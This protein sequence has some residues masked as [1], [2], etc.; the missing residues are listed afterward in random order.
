MKNDEFKTKVKEEIKEIAKLSE[1]EIQE[2][3]SKTLESEIY[4][5]VSRQIDPKW[6]CDLKEC[7][8]CHDSKLPSV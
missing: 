2:K 7:K 4:H 3:Y 8:A 6:K 1:D 5:E